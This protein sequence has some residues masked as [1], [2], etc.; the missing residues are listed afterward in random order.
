MSVDGFKWV[1][2]KSQFNKDFTTE[3]Y[4]EDSYKRYFLEVYIQYPEKLH[5]LHRYLPFL[6][7]IIKIKPTYTMKKYMLYTYEI[8]KKNLII[9]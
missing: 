4:N 7:E 1:E 5:D 3:N 9:D 6:P 2:D 8:S